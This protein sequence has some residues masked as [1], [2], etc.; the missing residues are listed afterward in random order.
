MSRPDAPAG[1]PGLPDPNPR[2]R[3]DAIAIGASAG[4]V[5]ALGS[6]LPA[7]PAGLATAVFVVLHLP[8]DQPSL[9]A[10]IFGRRCAL[11][12]HDAEDKAPVAPG[13]VY[14]ALPDY[15]LLIDAGPQLALSADAA[16]H[17]SRP[18]VD[19][20]FESAADVYAERLLAIVLTGAND[21]GAA[22]LR[23]VRQAGGLTV[24]QDPATAYAA[25]MP[26]A[27]I[28]LAAPDRVL[29]LEQIAALLADP[30]RG[31]TDNPRP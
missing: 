15:H 5:Q 27:A 7:L 25:Q 23:A 14:L 26:E 30:G 24:V 11:P 31:F 9:L 18:S 13:T 2:R 22:G 3:I 10:K 29:T 17:H 8:R 1:P 19:A 28:A 21:D 20:L 4:G 16:I 12:V 6:L